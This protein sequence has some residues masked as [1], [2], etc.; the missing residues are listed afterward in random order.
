MFA[1][2]VIYLDD[3]S[4]AVNDSN[5]ISEI[6]TNIQQGD[7]YIGKNVLPKAIIQRMVKYLKMVGTGSL[8]NYRKI[9]RGCPNFHRMNLWDPRAFVQG[10]F[11]Q[12]V[13]FPW[14]Q[15][16]FNLFE[17][18]RDVYH[19]KNLLSGN[20]RDKFL[21][22]NPEDG[23]T[24]RLAFQFYPKGTGGLNKHSDPVD[25]HQLSVPTLTMSKKG[26]DF[27][28]GG[29]YAEKENGEKIYLDDISEPGDVVYFNAII[30]HGVEK[31]DPQSKPDWLSF[32]GRWMLLFATNK[33]SDNA[34]IRD[35]VD[36]EKPK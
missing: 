8:P 13:F 19:M 16:V 20:P 9:E 22:I 21:G 15:D 36:L 18:T 27:K 24:A 33:L 4:K 11:H 32:E 34:S 31:I 6:R 17:M 28:E 10:C 30:P 14:N 29:A 26:I 3:H 25:H 2:D 23:C 12:F 35:A 1:R 5:Q 7:V